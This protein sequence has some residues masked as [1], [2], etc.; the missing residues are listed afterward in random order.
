V[1]RSYVNGFAITYY[2]GCVSHYSSAFID[3]SGVGG[4][5][6]SR[7]EVGGVML[8]VDFDRFLRSLS[9]GTRVPTLEADIGDCG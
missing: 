2:G 3:T 8:A 7:E 9:R 4:S 5:S 1:S 6:I